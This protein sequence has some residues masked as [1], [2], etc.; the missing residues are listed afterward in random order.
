[1]FLWV[2]LLLLIDSCQSGTVSSCKEGKVL[3]I[4]FPACLWRKW[5]HSIVFMA[6]LTKRAVC[7]Y[8]AGS[9]LVS[10]PNKSVINEA[11]QNR[12]RNERKMRLHLTESSSHNRY[13]LIK[14]FP[15]LVLWVW[16]PFSHFQWHPS[17]CWGTATP[18]PA[19]TASTLQVPLLALMGWGS[20]ACS[21]QGDGHSPG[22][23]T[24]PRDTDSHPCRA[25]GDMAATERCWEITVT[26]RRAAARAAEVSCRTRTRTRIMRGQWPF[27][28]PPFHTP[29]IILQ[30]MEP[31]QPLKL[32]AWFTPAP[33]LL[34]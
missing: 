24:Q 9:H 30:A 34:Q 12:C 17:S 29:S 8:S 31:L 11:A 6:V 27:S 23:Q 1:M 3:E 15:K 26:H 19:I 5:E 14:I 7:N 4:C 21:A 2:T 10:L 33:K 32:L 20:S 28:S 13:C 18:F 16:L 22:T 25:T